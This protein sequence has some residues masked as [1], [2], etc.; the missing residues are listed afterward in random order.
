MKKGALEQGRRASRCVSG[1]E[2][3]AGGSRHLQW[4]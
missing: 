2:G 4:I 3:R 1:G